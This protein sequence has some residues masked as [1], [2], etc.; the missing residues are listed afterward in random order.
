MCIYVLYVHKQ[1]KNHMHMK[2][3]A[4]LQEHAQGSWA[5]FVFCYLN[6]SEKE[7]GKKE[8]NHEVKKAEQGKEPCGC[9]WRCWNR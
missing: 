4:T 2:M 9:K 3:V 7:G 8:K 1:K 5:R 6:P